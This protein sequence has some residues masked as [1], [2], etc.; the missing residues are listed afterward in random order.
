MI[1]KI[2]G[3]IQEWLLAVFFKSIKKILFSTKI[4]SKFNEQ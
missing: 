3:H 1:F 4:V 2:M